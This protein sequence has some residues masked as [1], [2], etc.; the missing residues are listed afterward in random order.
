MGKDTT[1]TTQTQR[2]NFVILIDSSGQ[3][4][5]SRG[6][7]PATKQIIDIPESL[8]AHVSM[9]DPLLQSAGSTGKMTGVLLLP[10][11][12]LLVA[13]HPVISPNRE[14]PPHGFMLSARYLESAGDL[15]G[16]EKTTNFS[17]S[18]HRF[19]GEELPNDFSEARAHLRKPNDLYVSAIDDDVLGGYA[20]LYDIYGKPALILK[21]EMPRQ[22]YRQ[23]QASQL[24]F[25]A[26]LGISG[27]VFAVVVM[28]L[29]NT[30]VVARL[31]ALSASVAEIASSGDGAA[32]VDCPGS[33]ELSHLGI[34]I[35]FMLESLQLSQKIGR[36]SCRERV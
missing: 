4:F 28:L 15:K 22:M 2:L 32:R 25:V 7:D 23:G 20:S 18:V 21:A 27:V 11:G 24:Y 9:N 5:E 1:G 36:A 19:D 12:P 33:D 16:L 30:T 34:A 8:K 6:Y 10:E 13:C 17:L 26:S 35:N 31:T 3:I 29:L 14:G